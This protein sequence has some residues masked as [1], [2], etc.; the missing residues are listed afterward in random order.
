MKVTYRVEGMTC[1]GCARAV[2]NALQLI[3]PDLQIEVSREAGTVVVEGEHREEDVEQGVEAAGFD[4]GGR[5][6]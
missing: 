5:A 6:A 2:T 3:S 1:G 4:F